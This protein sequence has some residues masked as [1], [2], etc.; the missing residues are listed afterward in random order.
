MQIRELSKYRDEQGVISLQNRAL[1]TLKY[2]FDWYSEMQAQE[3]ITRKIGKVLGDEHT[4]LRNVPLVGTDVLAPLILFSPQGV[5]L[6]Q[7]SSAPGNFRASEDQ[8]LSFNNRTREF[9]PAQPNLQFRALAMARGLRRYFEAQ[10]YALPDLEAVLIFTNPQTLVDR[11]NPQARI[12]LADAIEHFGSSLQEREV[13]MDQDD[14]KMLT[15][16]LINPTLPEPERPPEPE[17]EP[18]PEQAV[19][20]S[21]PL[22][23]MDVR[24]EL[25]PVRRI[26]SFTMRQ[27][28]LLGV[29]AL[30]EFA[31]LLAIAFTV[32]ADRLLN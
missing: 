7:P 11:A 23:P 12:V 13:I 25:R 28:V 16:A 24:P 9:S 5:R 20:D 21:L 14:I 27:A 18:E 1:G 8:W 31:V 32:F 15:E 29:M 4:L 3:F 6:I 2:G 17:A 30:F 22:R 26:G 19:F 10:G